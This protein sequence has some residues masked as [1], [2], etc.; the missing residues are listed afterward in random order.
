MHAVVQSEVRKSPMDAGLVSSFDL[1]YDEPD[2]QN[3][4]SFSAVFPFVLSVH[5]FLPRYRKYSIR[6]F[7]VKYGVYPAYLKNVEMY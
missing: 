4:P 2:C 3:I 5:F 7:P 1:V 6:A